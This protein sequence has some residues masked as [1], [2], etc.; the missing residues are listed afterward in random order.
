MNLGFLGRLCPNCIAILCYVQESNQRPITSFSS[1]RNAVNNVSR[2]N[3]RNTALA[4]SP[5]PLS[6]TPSTRHSKSRHTSKDS[7]TPT[8]EDF[9][10]TFLKAQIDQLQN[11]I[12]D[13]DYEHITLTRHAMERSEQ[14]N[15]LESE[16]ASL[17]ESTRST[18]TESM[19]YEKLTEAVRTTVKKLN[20]ARSQL[21]QVT[22][23][24]NER[25]KRLQAYKTEL[26]EREVLLKQHKSKTAEEKVERGERKLK[27]SMGKSEK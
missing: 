18:S 11:K 22:V 21:A 26:D 2:Q 8:D 14:V 9:Y 4:R 25:L 10:E 24:K 27:S 23:S 7:I 17:I 1:L 5:H 20:D 12:D 19:E 13:L 6:F 16:V 15:S 3:V